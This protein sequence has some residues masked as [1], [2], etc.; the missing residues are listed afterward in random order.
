[1]SAAR[2]AAAAPAVPRVAMVLAAGRGKRMRSLTE[3]RPKPLIEVAGKPLID[4]GLDALAAAG[5][6]RAVV[7]LWYC[8]EMLAAHLATRERPAVELLRERTLLETGGGVANALPRLGEDAFFVVNSD[9]LWREAGRPALLRLADAWRD[10]AMDALLLVVPRARAIG[11]DGRGDFDI[12]A[13]GRLR[14]RA[15]AGEARYVFAGLQILHPRLFADAPGGAFSLNRVY[16]RALA[17]GRLYGVEHAGDW[18]H[19]GTPEGR[20][21]AERRLREGA[22]P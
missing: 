14:R 19:V 21:E 13:E 6:G 1:M 7:N 20:D 11:Y 15:D 8:A 5:V 3:T 2:P 10:E 16:D 9:I 22:G 18:F 12:E 4:H 17:A